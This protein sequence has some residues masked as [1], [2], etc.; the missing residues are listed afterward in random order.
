MALG[1]LAERGIN[2]TRIESR[3][4]KTR[5]WEY[6]FFTDIEGHEQNGMIGEAFKEMEKHCVLLKVLGSY[7]RGKE[8]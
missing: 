2:M 6:L 7:P 8:G 3:P 4:M 1:A 5:N